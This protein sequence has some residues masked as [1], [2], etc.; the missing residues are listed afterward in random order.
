MS[1]TIPSPPSGRLRRV[2]RVEEDEVAVVKAQV[3]GHHYNHYNGDHHH[4]R[5]VIV[6]LSIIQLVMIIIGQSVTFRFR[7]FLVSKLFHFLMVSVSV[8]E[9]FGIVK[10]SVSV[11]QIFGIGAFCFW[12]LSIYFGPKVLN[13]AGKL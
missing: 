7:N 5:C 1:F 8:S 6:I 11:S 3:S 9:I 10:V 2:G 4:N 12:P 13:M